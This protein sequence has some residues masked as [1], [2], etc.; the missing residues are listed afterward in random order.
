[1][2]PI[3]T[4]L[5]K[6]GSVHLRSDAVR[7]GVTQE[8]PMLT[9]MFSTSQFTNY[10][11]FVVHRTPQVI[12][13]VI[14][15]TQSF[16]MVKSQSGS[17]ITKGERIVSWCIGFL[18]IHSTFFKTNLGIPGGAIGDNGIWCDLKMTLSKTVNF[19]SSSDLWL[20]LY[21]YQIV[22]PLNR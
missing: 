6:N 7:L 15:F 22:L 12:R 3:S 19:N 18:P 17:M 14:G 16:S 8:V 20:V 21:A 9:L 4:L 11:G 2:S 13:C 10:R 5:I 1:M